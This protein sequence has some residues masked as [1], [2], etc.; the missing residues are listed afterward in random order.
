MRRML[1]ISALVI[2]AG[3]FALLG[4]YQYQSMPK[5]AQPGKEG[6]IPGLEMARFPGGIA[7]P[8]FTLPDVLGRP[9]RLKDFRGGYVL[10]N[11]R[12]TW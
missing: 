7:A 3:F 9:V 11:F 8:D 2:G 12:T 6:T 5:F 4:Y 10:L 1:V